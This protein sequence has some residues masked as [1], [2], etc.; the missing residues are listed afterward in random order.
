MRLLQFAGGGVLFFLALAIPRAEV[1][2]TSL[3]FFI[4][5]AGSG[6]GAKLGGLDGA[7]KICQSLA[8]AAGQGFPSFLKAL[9]R[10]GVS[11]DRAIEIDRKESDGGAGGRRHG[12]GGAIEG[13]RRPVRRPHRLRYVTKPSTRAQM[14]VTDS[15]VRGPKAKP[16]TPDGV[17]GSQC[18]WPTTPCARN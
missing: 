11:K 4:T 9:R 8:A 15:S 18:P 7:D 5:S 6:S 1:Q 10:L 13:E 3:S 2:D 16:R 17:R 14:R 12:K